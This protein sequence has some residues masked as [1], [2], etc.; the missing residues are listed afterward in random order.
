ML[1]RPSLYLSLNFS[2][3]KV[4]SMFKKQF[5]IDTSICAIISY[6]TLLFHIE[7]DFFNVQTVTLKKIA[8]NDRLAC[9]ASFPQ[10]IAF[11]VGYLGE[12]R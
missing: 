2:A 12:N 3:S 10:S 7:N 8:V 5:K 1:V 6:L 11:Q 9:H 4:E